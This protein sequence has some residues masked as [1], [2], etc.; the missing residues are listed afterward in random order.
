MESLA[1][2]VTDLTLAECEEFETATG[3]LITSLDEGGEVPIKVLTALVW[4]TK[5]REDSSF[6][7]DDAR[8]V[9]LSE[10]GQPDEN[11]TEGGS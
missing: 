9:K 1:I 7:L 11:P 8:K 5:R 2:N 3:V 4:L 6:T 10:V